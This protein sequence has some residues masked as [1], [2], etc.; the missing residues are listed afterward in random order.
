MFVEEAGRTR[1]YRK[2]HLR[3]LLVIALFVLVMRS[4]Q[5]RVDDAQPRD[6]GSVRLSSELVGIP[7][8]HDFGL[9]HVRVGRSAFVGDEDRDAATHE[10]V[11]FDARRGVG[12]PLL[13][14]VAG[15]RLRM[16]MPRAL[17]ARKAEGDVSVDQPTTRRE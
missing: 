11:P 10:V 14:R 16:A 1:Q 12:P 6:N 8:R 13:V 2:L 3:I 7:E 5:L 9:L 17:V 4:V 15:R